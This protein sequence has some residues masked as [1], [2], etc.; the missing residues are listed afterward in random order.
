MAIAASHPR[1]ESASDSKQLGTL[2][3]PPKLPWGSGVETPIQPLQGT[4]AKVKNIIY[5]DDS[6]K[7]RSGMQ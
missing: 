2:I 4:G 3:F 6:W 1:Y 5:Q 7:I